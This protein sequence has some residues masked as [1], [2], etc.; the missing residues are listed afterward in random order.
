MEGV[1]GRSVLAT[2]SRGKHSSE[3]GAV[4]TEFL[5]ELPGGAEGI[6]IVNKIGGYLRVC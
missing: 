5:D 1:L 6:G 2:S 4:T 3:K